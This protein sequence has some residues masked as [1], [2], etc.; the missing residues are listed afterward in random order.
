MDALRLMKLQSPLV[1]AIG[2]GS[3]GR[4]ARA[5]NR[6]KQPHFLLRCNI[7]RQDFIAIDQHVRHAEEI[8]DRGKFSVDKVAN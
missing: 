7:F 2:D 8:L 6:S 4:Q 5:L 3:R 1:L